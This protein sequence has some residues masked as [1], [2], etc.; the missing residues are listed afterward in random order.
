LH[1]PYS[2]YPAILT[3]HIH[4]LS[5]ISYTLLHIPYS[6]HSTALTHL[7]LSHTFCCVLSQQE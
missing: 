6:I 4:I 7:V 5:Y 3:Y 1:T 2:I